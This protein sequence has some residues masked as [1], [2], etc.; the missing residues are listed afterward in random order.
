MLSLPTRL[1]LINHQNRPSAP[2]GREGLGGRGWSSPGCAAHSLPVTQNR[3][4]RP[5]LP[6]RSQ[7]AGPNRLCS[8]R[9]PGDGRTAG[10]AHSSPL[11]TRNRPSVDLS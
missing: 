11:G 9:C 4:G 10:R 8:C 2:E 7:A 5:G 1:V 6:D 3:W